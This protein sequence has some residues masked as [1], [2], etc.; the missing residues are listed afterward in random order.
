MRARKSKEEEVREEKI[1]IEVKKVP[2]FPSVKASS[3]TFGDKALTITDFELKKNLG[4]GKFGIVYQA[5]HKQT[6]S[7][8]ALKKISKAMIKSHMMEDQFLL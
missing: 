2:E 4:E 6:N 1:N 7:L 8:F 5:F 3:N